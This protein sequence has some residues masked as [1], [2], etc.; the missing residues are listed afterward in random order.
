MNTAS[1]GLNVDNL[2]VENMAS[3]PRHS[4]RKI[5]AWMLFCSLTDT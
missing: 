3:H 1:A 2:E 5:L 4:T